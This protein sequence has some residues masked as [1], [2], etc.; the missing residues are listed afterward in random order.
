MKT[1]LLAVVAGA[2]ISSP[3]SAC[4]EWASY[5]TF[6]LGGYGTHAETVGGDIIGSNGD[7]RSNEQWDFDVSVY[8]GQCSHFADFNSS[9]AQG[10]WPNDKADIQH[11]FQRQSN[12]CV[13]YFRDVHARFAGTFC[14]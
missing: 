3:A 7:V 1:I 5:G 14:E 11:F 10:K 9:I 12:I 2:L 6:T 13:D 8:I 4:F